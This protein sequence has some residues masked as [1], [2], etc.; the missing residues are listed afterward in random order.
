MKD[1]NII[2]KIFM[3]FFKQKKSEINRNVKRAE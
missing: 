3:V 1:T 2:Y